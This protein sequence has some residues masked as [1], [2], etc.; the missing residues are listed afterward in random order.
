V[1]YWVL[2]HADKATTRAIIEG[3]V[4]PKSTILYTDEAS[5]YVGVHARHASV[6]H[7]IKEWARDDDGDGIREVHCNSCEGAGAAL[8]TFLRTFRGVHKYNL[9]DYVATYETMANAKRITPA[10]VRRMCFGDRITQRPHEP[11]S[12]TCCSPVGCAPCAARASMSNLCPTK[13]RRRWRN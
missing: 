10:V 11:R 9:A 2:E 8:R 3:N 1:R 5:N 12:K 13:M 6:C 4:P 7:S